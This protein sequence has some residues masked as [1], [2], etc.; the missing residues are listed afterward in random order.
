MGGQAGC[1]GRAGFVHIYFEILL[2]IQV[3]RSSRLLGM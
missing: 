1:E 2:D 3:E